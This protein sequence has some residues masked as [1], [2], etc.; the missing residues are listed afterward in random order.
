VADQDEQVALLPIWPMAD[1]G[2]D[3]VIATR[4][5]GVSRPPYDSLNLGLHVGDAEDRVVTNRERLAAT[6]GCHL[7]DMVYLDQS[8]GTR[9][10]T[11]GAQHAGRGARFVE[12]ALSATDAAVTTVV[13]LPLV[14]LVADCS[15]IVLV[16]PVAGVLGV[17]HAGWRGAVAGI[18]AATV[19]AMVA[20][21]AERSRLHGWIGPGV[22][23]ERY[24]V[25][26]EV[27]VAARSGGAGV[28]VVER[29]G[30][31]H[32]DM[33]LLNRTMLEAAGVPGDQLAASEL[34]TADPRL[35]SDRHARPC[36]RF[37]LVARLTGRPS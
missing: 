1:L 37:A 10:A 23:V 22:D 8:H 28:A 12:N 32:L 13:G 19:A 15:P 6:F 26:P 2:V 34:T 5:G 30:G 14:I 3:A 4:A 16:D 31:T 7:D 36:G 29:E 35:F 17:V 9:V 11:V 21:G 27:V 18:G 25:G 33:A 24:Q 20:A